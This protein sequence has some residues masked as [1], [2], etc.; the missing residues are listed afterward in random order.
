MQKL[1]C[2]LIFGMMFGQAELTTRVY[3]VDLSLVE[4]DLQPFSLSEISNGD[5]DDCFN[6]T[7]SEGN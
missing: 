3:E 4:Q 2:I 7:C 1:L 6:Y 5:L